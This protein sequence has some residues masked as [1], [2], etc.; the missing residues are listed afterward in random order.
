M[1]RL[2]AWDLFGPVAIAV[3]SVDAALL[4]VVV[5]LADLPAS[6]HVFACAA[7]PVAVEPLPNETDADGLGFCSCAL[8]VDDAITGVGGVAV[9][10]GNDD[11]NGLLFGDEVVVHAVPNEIVGAGAAAGLFSMCCG[12]CGTGSELVMT[13]FTCGF[14]STGAFFKS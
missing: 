13:A 11:D 14:F 8:G 6:L 5:I 12:F 4:V 9:G 2:F 7:G 3:V 10:T 1:N